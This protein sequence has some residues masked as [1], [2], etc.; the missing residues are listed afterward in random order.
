M[1]AIAEPGYKHISRREDGDLLVTG[2][3]FKVIPLIG[4]H[5]VEGWDAAELVKQFPLLTL[6]QAH[7]VLGYYYDNREAVEEAMKERD[8]E[9]ARLR[10]ETADL[11]SNIRE[12]LRMPAGG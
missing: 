6:G 3:R 10:E 11:R 9:I 4:W 7:A 2:T 1:K 8:R 5:L 12:K